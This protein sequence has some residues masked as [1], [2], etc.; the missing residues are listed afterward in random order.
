MCWRS[1]VRPRSATAP[2]LEEVR[3]ARAA[4]IRQLKGHGDFVGAGIG[5]GRG[6]QLIVQVNW[7]AKPSDIT[8]LRRIGRVGIRHQVVGSLEPFAEYF[9]E[10]E[11]K[12]RNADAPAAA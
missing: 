6:G 2:T 10:F 7:R 5:R 12:D 3:E 1:A 11:S 9:F 8:P 4:V